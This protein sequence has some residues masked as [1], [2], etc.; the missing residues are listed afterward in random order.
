MYEP[1]SVDINE[2]MFNDKLRYFRLARSKPSNT[3]PLMLK[4]P[5]FWM[6]PFCLAPDLI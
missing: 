4:G 5:V 2:Y 3:S 1:S 6:V